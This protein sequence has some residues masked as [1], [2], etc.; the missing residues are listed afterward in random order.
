MMRIPSPE[1]LREIESVRAYPRLVVGRICWRHRDAVNVVPHKVLTNLYPQVAGIPPPSG[2]QFRLVDNLIQV[3]RLRPNVAPPIC[4]LRLFIVI[5][6]AVVQTAA[7][8]LIRAIHRAKRA[9][10]RALA[11]G[12]ACRAP[13]PDSY[14]REHSRE[15]RH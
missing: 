13:S 4:R 11:D 10:M 7:V 3:I 8:E 9:E 1:R 14:S 12:S 6:F 2:T 15:R 5:I